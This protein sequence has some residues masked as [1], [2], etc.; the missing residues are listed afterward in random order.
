MCCCLEELLGDSDCMQD[1]KLQ[2]L[3]RFE[4]QRNDF[5]VNCFLMLL[6]FVVGVC[7]ELVWEMQKGDGD[8]K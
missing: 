5:G 1:T 7:C 6:A 4:V 2:S 8:N 3:K